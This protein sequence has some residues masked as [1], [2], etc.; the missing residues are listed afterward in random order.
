M[1]TRLFVV[2][3]AVLLAVALLLPAAAPAADSYSAYGNALRQTQGAALGQLSVLSPQSY[4]VRLGHLRPLSSQSYGVQLGQVHLLTPQTYGS[5]LANPTGNP[6][7][8][9][10]RFGNADTSTWAW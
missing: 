1:N 4:G 3:L 7:V 2:A 5:R 6:S 8:I 10:Y 9:P